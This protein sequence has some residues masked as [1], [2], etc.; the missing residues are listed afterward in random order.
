MQGSP[1]GTIQHH[2]HRYRR[3][4]EDELAAL[5]LRGCSEDSN[6]EGGRAERMPPHRDVVQILEDAHAKGANRACIGLALSLEGLN[7]GL[8]RRTLGDKNRSV[9]S[10][11]LVRVRFIVRTDGSC[12]RD[13]VTL[14]QAKLGEGTRIS[15]R[16][17]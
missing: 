4:S 2:R 1:V 12:S 7:R 10:D 16:V 14:A 3:S 9:D 6:G 17:I 5:V 13:T 8:L 15:S 11:R